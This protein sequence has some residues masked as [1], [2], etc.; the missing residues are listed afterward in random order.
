[1]FWL[2]RTKVQG[3]SGRHDPWIELI[4]CILSQAGRAWDADACCVMVVAIS[5]SLVPRERET[6]V[7]HAYFMRAATIAVTGENKA[8]DLGPRPSTSELRFR[9]QLW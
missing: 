7:K 4:K 9:W 2:L 3:T 8:E 6:N 1:V 5:V